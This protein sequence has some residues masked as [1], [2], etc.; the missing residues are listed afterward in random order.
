MMSASN[1]PQN[2]PKARPGEDDVVTTVSGLVGIALQTPIGAAIDETTDKRRA[3][4][5]ALA[6]LGASAVT[7]LPPV[8]IAS[9]LARNSTVMGRPP[10]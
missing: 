4:V 5:L 2:R 3:I 8:A 10:T 1:D 7:R 9:T 6:V